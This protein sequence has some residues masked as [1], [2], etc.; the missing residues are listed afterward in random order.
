MFNKD[1]SRILKRLAHDHEAEMMPDELEEMLNAELAKPD[2]EIDDQLVAEILRVLEPAEPSKAQMEKSWPS[3]LNALPCRRRAR[4]RLIWLRRAAVLIVGVVAALTVAYQSADALKLTFLRKIIEPFEETFSLV[5][6]DLS[7]EQESS[8]IYYVED[9]PSTQVEY[10]A[11]EDVPETD[12]IYAVRPR[13]LPEGFVFAGGS[14]FRSSN[15]AIY[16]MDFF[17]G[18]D[19]LGY[20]VQIFESEE[21][22]FSYHYEMTLQSP[23]KRQIGQAEVAFYGNANSGIQA[24]SWEYENANY[25]LTGQ[26]TQE[27]IV[28]FV[29]H[30]N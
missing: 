27:D 12:G 21:S 25:M 8:S 19:W 22:E 24:A 13:W 20:T 3:V 29:E 6:D 1:E 7:S 10:A 17:R 11:W 14:L 15:T 30:L 2:T 5:I 26:I 16:S 4:R 18:D 23:E 28:R 9:L